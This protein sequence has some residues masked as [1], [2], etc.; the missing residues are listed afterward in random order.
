LTRVLIRPAE[1]NGAV[2][3]D[4]G[5]GEHE[6][7]GPPSGERK[8]MS[9]A[10]RS[11]APIPLIWPEAISCL[12]SFGVIGQGSPSTVSQRSRSGW[13]SSA[14]FSTAVIAAE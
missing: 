14:P 7:S 2:Q 5:T 9:S 4:A 13:G 6:G 8:L 1:P 3:A 11:S 12:T 10:W